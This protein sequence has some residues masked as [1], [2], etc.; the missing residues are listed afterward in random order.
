MNHLLR[1]FVLSLVLVL[2]TR[3]LHAQEKKERRARVPHKYLF[4]PYPLDKNWHVSLGF[5]LTTMP[6]DITEEVQIRAPAGDFHVLRKLGKG[7]Y[8]D[9]R[10]NFQVLQNHISIGP[11]WAKV[12]NDRFSVSVGDDMAWWFGNLNVSGFNTKAHGWLNYPNASIGYRFKKQVLM[13]LKGE[14]SITLSDESRVGEQLLE[15]NRTRFNGVGGT[16]LIEQPFY[17]NKSIILGFKGQ[18][19][20]FYWQTWP[21][22]ETFDR[23]IFYPEIIVGFIL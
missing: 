6:E 11:R 15:N 5:T 1:T 17:K 13:T 12:L 18:Y 20:N 22:F 21:L 4:F 23:T 14:A 7:F 10:V 8:L 3:I 19:T 16:I 2:T 9:G